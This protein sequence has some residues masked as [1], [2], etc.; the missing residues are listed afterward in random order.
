[1]LIF[2]SKLLAFIL[3]PVG[4]SCALSFIGIAA[5]LLKKRRAALFS[6]LLS[7]LILCVFSMPLVSHWLIRDLEKKFDP[8]ATFPHVSAIVVLGGSTEPAVPPRRYVE[9]NGFGDRIFHALRLAK[10][11]YA[12]YIICT[13]GKI[14]YLHD[15]PGSE[16]ESM[17][18]ILKEFG[19]FDTT[20]III[21]DK[22]QNTHDHGPKVAQIL[23]SKG[24][25]KEIILITSAMHM[26]RSVKI[27]KKYGFTVYPAPTDYWTETKTQLNIFC[28]FPDANSLNAST[29]ALHEYYGLVAYKLLGWL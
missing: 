28:F 8:P 22:A 24:L 9:T 29:V 11:H 27:F 4:I 25:K 20:S 15:F 16:A 26:Y 14:S 19:E 3:Y 10:A 21:E 12:P 6:F 5:I 18:Q 13:G 7:A 17:A 23:N 2:L 1:M